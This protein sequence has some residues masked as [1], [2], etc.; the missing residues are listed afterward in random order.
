MTTHEYFCIILV[1]STLVVANGRHVFDHDRMVWML[2]RLV[3][4]VVGC[5]HVVDDI[6]LA[7]L[8]ASELLLR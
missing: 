3:E 6:A 4:N 8:L 1:E 2:V 7:D 5:D